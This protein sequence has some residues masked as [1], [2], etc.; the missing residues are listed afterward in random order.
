MFK[1]KRS[2]KGF[3]LIELMVTVVII[4]ILARIAIPSYISSVQKS[5]RSDAKSHLLQLSQF[6]EQNYTL[7]NSYILNSAGG[8]IG[9]VNTN[10]PAALIISPSTGTKYYDLSFATP[11]PTATSYILQAVP[12][13]G[14]AQANDPCGTLT[15]T[16]TGVT[17]AA[18]TSGCW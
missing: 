9:P 3:T 12:V 16:N 10:L 5:R 17:T 14:S 11:A 15:I 13:N 7:T 6:L 18:A 1:L 2:E 4:A 8:T